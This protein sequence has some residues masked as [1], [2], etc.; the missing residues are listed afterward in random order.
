M[1]QRVDHSDHLLIVQCR[2]LSSG[3]DFLVTFVYARNTASLRE[4]LWKHL[5]IFASTFKGPWLLAEDFN[6]IRF[7]DEKLGGNPI[8]S[9]HLHSFNKCLGM[10]RLAEIHTPGSFLTWTNKEGH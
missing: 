6:C 7:A 5:R 4:H 9:S 8:P 2:C 3:K 1:I 10:C